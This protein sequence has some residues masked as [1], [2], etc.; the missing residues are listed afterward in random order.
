MVVR[1]LASMDIEMLFIE[2]TR[3]DLEIL[4]QIFGPAGNVFAET[5]QLLV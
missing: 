1:Q 2:L 3:N 4:K 5:V